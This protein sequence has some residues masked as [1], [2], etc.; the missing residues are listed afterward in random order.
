[1][2]RVGVGKNCDM[3][4]PLERRHARWRYGLGSCVVLLLHLSLY[5]VIRVSRDHLASDRIARKDLQ[6]SFSVDHGSARR[7]E[8]PSRLSEGGFR[9]K[10]RRRGPVDRRSPTCTLY[11]I[12]DQEPSPTL[13]DVYASWFYH[14]E[15]PTTHLPQLSVIQTAAAT[16]AAAQRRRHE[17]S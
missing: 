10:H 2:Q 5:D 3:T 15:T 1:M 11:M 13:A 16:A 14:Y 6:C 12:N 4:K 17:R 7:S 8:A 9:V